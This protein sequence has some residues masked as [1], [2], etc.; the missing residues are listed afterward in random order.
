MSKQ[1]EQA[2]LLELY[3]AAL[4][5]D[6]AAAPPPALDAERAALARR[7]RQQLRPNQPTAAYRQQLRQMIAAQA[8]TK[9]NSTAP[10]RGRRNP[11]MQ[12]QLTL[13][14][15]VRPLFNRPPRFAVAMLVLVV[16]ASTLI[17]ASQQLA[18]SP[19]NNPAVT[20]ATVRNPSSNPTAACANPV[21]GAW[22]AVAA[23]PGTSGG[24]AMV[25]D[26]T[27]IYATASTLSLSG[28]TESKQLLRYDPAANSWTAL[29]SA[30]SDFAVANAVYVPGSKKLYFFGGVHGSDAAGKGAIVNDTRIYDIASNSWSSGAAM[31]EIRGLAA[32]GYWNGKIYL[33]GGVLSLSVLNIG[34]QTWEY[35]PATDKWATRAALPTRSSGFG[36]G[37]INGHLYVTA[38][39]D[40]DKSGFSRST[41][42]YDIAA[43]K[44]TAR[45]DLLDTLDYPGS[46]VVGDRLYIFGGIGGSRAAARSQS[47]VYDPAANLW[48]S[49]PD[50]AERRMLPGGASVGNTVLVVGG[51]QGSN[52][53]NTVE[54]ATVGCE[55]APPLAATPPAQTVSTDNPL[56]FAQTGKVVGGKFRTYW[57][58][59]GGL[60]QQGYPISNEFQEKNDTDDKT[61]TVQYFERAVFEMHPENAAPNDVLLSQLGTFRYK[62]KYPNGAAGQSVSS[63]NASRFEQTSH[64]VGGRFRTYWEAHGG[65]AQQ[66]YPISD[67]FQEKSD[68]DGKTYSVQYFERAVF[69]YHPENAGT[70]YEVQLSQL[71]S[72]RYKQQYPAAP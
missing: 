71:G 62:A 50:M 53:L 55:A 58:T 54:A 57:E 44:W 27:Y 63:D 72:F 70:A 67:E 1:E 46:A 37:V 61:Y 7:L 65:L 5:T 15:R 43:D 21:L 59:H 17:F 56:P 25:S 66:G 16:I 23:L 8:Q 69:E 34:N 4:T 48:Q 52:L 64:S 20:E 18:T 22:R 29:A 12:T 31:P 68:T 47:Y 30:P 38:G 33:V 45:A 36:Y 28:P 60:A 2:E 51:S 41:Y 13:P 10:N 24:G 42:D 9:P 39:Y 40:L 19:L 35:D 14:T 11:E 26:G 32:A 6:L 3:L 49:G